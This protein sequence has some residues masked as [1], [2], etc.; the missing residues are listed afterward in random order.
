MSKI[1][2]FLKLNST[3]KFIL[4]KAFF[5]LLT[6]RIMLWILPFS[7]IQKITRRLTD[8]SED[9]M[10]EISIEKLTWAI[11]V[12]SIYTPGATCLTRAI[13]AQ[14]LL[15]RYNYS[16]SIKI[17]VSKNDEEFEAHAWLEKDG[18]IILGESETQYT[19]IMDMG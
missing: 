18:G 6:V 3:E 11:R 2:T 16:S 8:V 14:I 1:K 4:I 5:L 13:A 10:S 7:F 17:G 19:P 9:M 12:M 15:A